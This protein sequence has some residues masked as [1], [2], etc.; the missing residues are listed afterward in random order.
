MCGRFTLAAPA[1]ELVEVFSVPLPDFDVRPR[2]NV[3]PGQDVLV[4][5]EDRRG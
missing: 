2:W 5:G 1:E 4:V 3:A